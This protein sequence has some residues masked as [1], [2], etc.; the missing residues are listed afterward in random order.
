MQLTDTPML[1]LQLWAVLQLQFSG[2]NSSP[3]SYCLEKSSKKTPAIWTW[4]ILILNSFAFLQYVLADWNN[5][6]RQKQ[7]QRT[8]KVQDSLGDRELDTYE[9]GI[10]CNEDT[11]KNII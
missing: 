6:D 7:V 4:L 1:V 9:E 11:N 10:F 8:E 3:V 5:S 2:S